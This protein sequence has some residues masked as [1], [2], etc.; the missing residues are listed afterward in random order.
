LS[1][2][3]RSNFIVI[4]LSGKEVN[5]YEEKKKEFKQSFTYLS[6]DKSQNVN[7]RRELIFKCFDKWMSERLNLCFGIL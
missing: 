1:G 3:S 7:T 4:D 5:S 2:I 6:F